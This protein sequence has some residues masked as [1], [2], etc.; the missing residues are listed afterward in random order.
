[1]NRASCENTRRRLALG[2]DVGDRETR[3]HLA[4]CAA[5]AAEAAR[6]RCVVD[7]LDRGLTAGVPADLD[8]RVRVMLSDAPRLPATRSPRLVL[9]AGVVALIAT[10]ASILEGLALAGAPAE[11]LWNSILLVWIYLILSS[12]ATIPILSR[13][14]IMNISRHGGHQR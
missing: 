11:K 8:L 2:E 9:T 12:A 3:E 14:G 10:I 6:L 7:A 1:M 4:D 5:C 13:H